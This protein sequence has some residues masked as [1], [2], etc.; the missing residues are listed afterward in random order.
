M[1][2]FLPIQTGCVKVKGLWAKCTSWMRVNDAETYVK[3]YRS[4]ESIMCKVVWMRFW[5]AFLLLV[6][7][8]T[9]DTRRVNCNASV[10]FFG[11]GQYKYRGSWKVSCFLV[12]FKCSVLNSHVSDSFCNTDSIITLYERTCF[13]CC[14]VVGTERAFCFSKVFPDGRW[15]PKLLLF[16]LFTVFTFSSYPLIFVLCVSAFEYSLKLMEIERKVITRMMW[17][18]EVSEV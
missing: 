11:F 2:C 5:H 4:M 12:L 10:F 1:H 6:R 16:F 15:Q 3:C 7:L 14:G 18:N 17:S 13:A 9:A 8:C